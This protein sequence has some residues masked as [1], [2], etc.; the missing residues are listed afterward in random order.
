MPDLKRGHNRAMPERRRDLVAAA[1]VV[2]AVSCGLAAVCASP[3]PGMSPA[4]TAALQ[5]AHRV[6]VAGVPSGMMIALPLTHAPLAAGRASQT[7]QTVQ[8]AASSPAARAC[9]GLPRFNAAAVREIMA[10]EL[11]VP[12]FPAV[13]IDP[14]RDGNVNWY[15][16]P[17]GDPTWVLDFQQA[18]WIEQLV[19]G[20]LKGGPDAAA[21]LKRAA[22][23]TRSWLNASPVSRD[24]LTLVCLAQAFPGQA[25]ITG[26]IAPTVNWYAANWQGAYNHGLTQDI[27]LLRIG[28][29][30]PA[31]AF[32][33]AALSWRNTAVRQMIA[34]FGP[35]PYAPAIDAQGAVNEQATL[36]ENFVYNLWRIGLPLLRSCGYTL[37]GSI[38]A[39]IAKLPA[40]LSY[41]TQP[42]GNL[43]QLG[44]TYVERPAVRSAVPPTTVP[45][46]TGPPSTG[47]ANTVPSLVAVYNAGFIFGRS[48]WTPAASFYS[49]RFGPGR[50]IHGHNDHMGLTYYA[51]GRNLI[52]DAGHYGYANTPYRTW[53]L[54][55][56]AAST[57]V[58]PGVSFNPDAPTALIASQADRRGQFYQF[59]DTAFGG[60]PRSRS[61]FVSQQPDLVVVFDQA[62]AG[63]EYQ[64]LWHLD[65][66]LTIT[67]IA[68]T[69][70]GT[71]TGTEVVATA[72]GT[73]LVLLR[74]PLPGQR[75][76]AGSVTVARAQ[77]SPLQGWVSHQLEQRTP[78]DVVEMTSYGPAAAM[79][80]VIVPA[81]PGARVTA[82]AT[83]P[84]AGPY[85]L[86]VRVGTA[87]T[88]FTVTGT[89]TIS[90]S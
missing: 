9:G 3:G 75:I 88:R 38:T 10:G 60:L 49:L 86:T 20:Y 16:N 54:S 1:V 37:P 6:A 85:L 53:L 72:P 82:A 79:L 48:G 13:K 7:A 84:E 76:T 73:E 14:R 35:N 65:P 64:Q 23:L 27:N 30:Y 44:D 77:A 87:V 39:R 78:D 80:T 41:A 32:G 21:Y 22:Q 24:P 55:P 62:A 19:A 52:V 11:T 90:R 74:V 12:P 5:P 57:F 31:T 25:W 66:A 26:Q 42:D 67:P 63:G 29:A 8:R 28:C 18:G 59:Y 61:V 33:G 15:L 56:E 68:G 81:A 71:P 17:F 89:G 50:E 70:S 45:P 51:R 43:V 47:P 40:F 58:I 46:T 69:P 4:L 83:G 36:Y 34:S 2:T